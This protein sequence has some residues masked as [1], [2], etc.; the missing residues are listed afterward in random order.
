MVVEALDAEIAKSEDK[1]TKPNILEELM[2]RKQLQGRSNE[3]I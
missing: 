1:T 2:T 3:R